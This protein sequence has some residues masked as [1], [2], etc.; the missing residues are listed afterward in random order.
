MANLSQLFCSSLTAI[1]AHSQVYHREY[2]GQAVALKVIKSPE[3]S[4]S[5][6]DGL[7]KHFSWDRNTFILDHLLEPAMSS[8]SLI[9]TPKADMPHQTSQSTVSKVPEPMSMHKTLCN[10]RNNRVQ[11][12]ATNHEIAAKPLLKISG[13]FSG[14]GTGSINE[15]EFRSCSKRH[16]GRWTPSSTALT[17][18]LLIGEL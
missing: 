6:R 5:I 11:Y 16:S 17:I 10:M 1:G 2:K 8:H 3:G 18:K 4:K 15:S 7:E 14:L 12:P 9:D 13:S